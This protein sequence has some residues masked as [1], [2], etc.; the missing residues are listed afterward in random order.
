MISN[1]LKFLGLVHILTEKRKAE[2]RKPI[3]TRE[4]TEADKLNAA[5]FEFHQSVNSYFLCSLFLLLCGALKNSSDKTHGT[6]K[7]V[8]P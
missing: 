6:Y 2:K 5:Y 4:K 1:R 3:R 8:R 7:N